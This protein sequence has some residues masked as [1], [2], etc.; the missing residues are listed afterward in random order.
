MKK[1]TT[2]NN[3]MRMSDVI[4][5]A[6]IVM[7]GGLYVAI[8]AGPL[9]MAAAGAMIGGILGYATNWLVVRMLFWPRK[10]CYLPAWLGGG[11][12][13]MTPGLLV[14]KQQTLAASIGDTVTKRL[15]SP[16]A[17][18]EVLENADTRQKIQSGIAGTLFGWC[19]QSYPPIAE[20]LGP[21]RLKEA[22][23][24]RDRAADFIADTSAG[25]IT[26]HATVQQV[27][28][29]VTA[30][31]RPL[32]A[33]PLSRWI[34]VEHRR[35]LAQALRQMLA[36]KCERGTA[37]PLL[38]QEAIRIIGQ[39][40]KKAFETDG[41][42]I[43]REI[44]SNQLPEMVDKTVEELSVKMKSKE[45]AQHFQR[46]IT[47]AMV[48]AIADAIPVRGLPVGLS[49]LSD[50]GRDG[51]RDLLG[52]ILARRWDDM[53][54][55]LLGSASLRYELTATL[56]KRIET[57]GDGLQ[58]SADQ[59]HRIMQIAANVLTVSIAGIIEQPEF[60]D[61]IYHEISELCRKRTD[62][63][64]PDWENRVHELLAHVAE[65]NRHELE[66]F[67]K[68]FVRHQVNKTAD[69]IIFENPLGCPAE[70]FG[71]DRT[72]TLCNGVAE[73]LTSTLIRHIETIAEVAPFEQIISN[74]INRFQPDE[75]EST[76]RAVA[77][78]ELQ[79]IIVLGG[80]LGIAAGALLRLLLG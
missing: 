65:T 35:Q 73:M 11:R 29:A 39:A 76:V 79:A 64:I 49:F 47:E 31:L 57:I 12:I 41:I 44:A 61:I 10:T 14:A 55:K 60:Q 28:A 32:A 53:V 78:S 58:I 25:V 3:R 62:E 1:N 43:V 26:R 19:G 27:S 7:I 20:L 54:D 40:A 75:I 36:D 50:L 24:W 51:M 6:C 67:V 56:R 70:R 5:M 22:I 63:L 23:Q 15:L 9:K 8:P 33:A 4:C 45:Q 46:Q 68:E 37:A 66:S 77:D 18:R 38:Q 17:I 42:G 48:A 72:E 13:P 74:S 34:T 52:K 16:A 30:R 71:R 80:Y 69:E 21:D 2:T 59:Q